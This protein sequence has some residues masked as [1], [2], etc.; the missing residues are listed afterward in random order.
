MALGNTSFTKNE[1]VE[2]VYPNPTNN[3]LTIKFNY[4]NKL[5]TLEIMDVSGKLILKMQTQTC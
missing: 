5:H 1:L 4:P 3:E 2:S